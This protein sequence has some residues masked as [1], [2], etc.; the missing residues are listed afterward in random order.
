MKINPVTYKPNFGRAFTTRESIAYSE[1]LNDARENLGLEDT[2]AII[3]DFNIPS[4]KKK[5]TAIG[6][7]WS[8]AMIPFIKFTEKMTGITSV[9]LEP[10]GKITSG[11]A[12]PYS[13]TTFAFGEHIIDL[14]KLT[15]KRYGKLLSAKYIK[16]L[17]K[18]YPY[19]K[20][21]RE[22]K[23][24][25][26]YVTGTPSETGIQTKA[27][28]LAFNNFKKGIEEKNPQIL[29]LNSEFNC[30]K[31]ENKDWL[32]KEALFTVLSDIYGTQN[33][34]EWSEPDKNLYD[35]NT[36]EQ[37]RQNRIKEL[38]EIRKDDMEFSD[39]VQFLADK[40]QKESHSFT[41]SKNIKLYGDCL[42][43]FS[44]S[45][46]WANKEC[47]RENLYYGGPDPN[48]PDT[49][50]IQTWGL[51]ALDYTKLGECGED[52]DIS[53]LGIAGKLLFD[54][55]TTFF[56]RYDGIRADAAWQFVTP[57]VYQA[58]NGNYEEVK[59]PEINNT[60][61]NIM[62]A[63]AKKAK[64]SGEIMLEMVG[65]SADKGRNMTM[66][67][68]PHL[69]STA[70]AE[71]DETPAKF[72]E[73]G[74][75]DG[76]FYTGA[77]NHDND[78]LINMAIDTIKRA[79][80]LEGMKRD[81]HLDENILKFNNSAYR[82]NSEEEQ[83]REDFRTA[84]LAEIFTAKKQFF[85]L[86]DMFGMSER[87]NISGKADDSNWTVRIPSDYE[88]FYFS[89]LA[90][91]YGIN[92]PKVLSVAMSMKHSNINDKLISKCNEAAEILREKG[93]MTQEEADM[94]ERD[95]TLKHQF[96]Y[97]R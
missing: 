95:G 94:A 21:K 80:H 56:K 39:F 67:K 26:S 33:F 22:Y 17:D 41:K 48:C 4:E 81:Y 23:T 82:S 10:Q 29:K 86:P 5:N 62:I 85:T 3:F 91:G 55:Y 2:S 68:Y 52:G 76:M 16:D 92:M 58:V 44:M 84:K 75:K 61:F 64:S 49:N 27:L 78:S 25:Y 30:F 70:Y 7:T 60:I 6:T 54:K 24:D 69:Y 9:Q 59:M 79:L 83:K 74:Y 65:I 36:N 42:L 73:K 87:I 77:G 14:T 20:H 32:E 45:E 8:Q 11:N 34:N 50:Y 51:P 53:K 31:R 66:N 1:L 57:F 89:Q 43:G 15:L 40:Q 47:F 19:D 37:T 35:T 97:I 63:A 88:R 18:N 38:K 46:M 71:Y 28:N 13:G 96:E 90:N 12:S 93:P 72:L